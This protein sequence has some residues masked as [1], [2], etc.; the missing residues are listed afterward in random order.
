[1]RNTGRGI[2]DNRKALDMLE[3]FASVGVRA[4]DV[5]M[6]DIKGDKIPRGFQANRGVDQLRAGIGPALERATR[7]RENFIIRPRSTTATLVQLDDLPAE[8]A[9][10]IAR[11]AFMV[12]CTS[13]GNFQAWVAVKDVPPDFARRLRKGAGADPSASG[14]TRISGSLNF[15]TKYAPAFPTVEITHAAHGKITTADELASVGLVAPAEEAPRRVPIRVSQNRRAG[16]ARRWPSYALCVQ[17][18]PPIHQGD[19]PDI[20]RADFTWCM[21]AID[22][23][24]SPEDTAAR[25]ML[26]SSK[27][28]ENGEGYAVQTATR[29]AEAVAR[30]EGPSNSPPAPGAPR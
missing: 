9:A 6:T 10:A 11:H 22:W 17:K 8:A 5:T 4:F 28:Q 3:A 2:V 14:A 21:L 13:P 16:K 27:A 18:A 26:E 15:K 29:A 24:H 30:R 12:L 25:L 19:R 7:A 23:G 1:M 20:S